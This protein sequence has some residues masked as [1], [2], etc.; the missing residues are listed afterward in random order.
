MEDT[1]TPKRCPL[2]MVGY[3]SYQGQ[4]RE[5][6]LSDTT[7]WEGCALWDDKNQQC[8]ILTLAVQVAPKEDK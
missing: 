7:C 1:D 8:A 2:L 6:D 5:Q 3:L 4:E